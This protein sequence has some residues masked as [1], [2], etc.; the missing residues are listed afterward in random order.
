MKFNSLA[1]MQM[2]NDAGVYT[3]QDNG[4]PEAGVAVMANASRFVEAHRLA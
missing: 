1:E 3:P 2:A 4:N